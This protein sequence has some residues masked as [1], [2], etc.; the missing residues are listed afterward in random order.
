MTFDQILERAKPYAIGF[1]VGA[2]AAPIIA[3]NAGWVTTTSASTLAAE[4]A[5]IDALTGVCSSAAGRMATAGSMDLTA[6]KGYDNR[7]KRDE[8]VA[9]ILAD[10]QVPADL[11]GK[12]GT[13]CSRTLS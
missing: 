11:V 6:L 10:I 9:L 1:V 13:S 8:L 5:R 12:V 4:T 2:F 7:A 3:F